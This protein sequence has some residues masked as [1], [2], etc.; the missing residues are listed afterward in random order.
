MPLDIT[1]VTGGKSYG[2]PFVGPVDHPAHVKVDISGLTTKE[3]D[4]SGYLKPGV[5]LEEDGT[6]VGSGEFVFGVTIEAV[7][8]PLVTVPPTNDTLATE[9]HDC[10]V[11]VGTIG[12]VNQDIMEDNLDRA[13]TADEI[14]GFNLAGSKLVLL[15]T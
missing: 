7:K 5:P 9:T 6:T 1:N 8:L 11:A 15:P 2:N 13:L 3:V 4:S 14:A 12:Q 10:F